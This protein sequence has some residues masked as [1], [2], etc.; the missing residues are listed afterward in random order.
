MFL[1]ILYVLFCVNC[2]MIDG[3]YVLIDIRLCLRV[4]FFYLYDFVSDIVY[5]YIY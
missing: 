5:N 4:D 1:Y 2:F 3:N